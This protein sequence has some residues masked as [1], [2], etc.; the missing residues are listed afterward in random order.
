VRAIVI[1]QPGGPEVLH[2]AE[3]PDPSPAPGEVVVELRSA[4]VN[5]RDVWTRSEGQT[6]AGSVPGS[7]GAGVVA[8][9][10]P[11]G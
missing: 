9:H 1:Q 2:A 8:E 3:L 7:D 10:G 5:H 4:A 11:S 6:P